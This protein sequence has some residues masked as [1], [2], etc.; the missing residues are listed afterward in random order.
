MQSMI[1][2]PEREPSPE[3]FQARMNLPARLNRPARSFAATIR[4]FYE[5]SEPVSRQSAPAV[6]SQRKPLS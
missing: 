3:S 1:A 6:I 2:Q 5:A 4:R